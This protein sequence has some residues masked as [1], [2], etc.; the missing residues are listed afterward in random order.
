MDTSLNQQTYE[1][2]K[3]DILTFALKPGEPVSAQ[4][5]AERYDVSRTPAREALVRLQDEGMVDI[6]PQSRS[7]IS[8][9]KRDRIHQEWY[10]R[11]CL[12]LGMVDSFFDKVRKEDI[13][14]MKKAVVQLSKLGDTPRTHETSF[15]YI[16]CDDHFHSIMYY[17]TGESLAASIIENTLLN[18]R[19]VRLLVD[20]DNINKDRTVDDHERLIKLLEKKDREGYRLLL[21]EHLSHIIED[22]K[23]LYKQFPEMFEE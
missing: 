15:D 7:V 12:E 5:I 9:I 4:R 10:V 2:L 17:V 13:S 23:R 1:K 18:Y 16:N 11:K 14:E 22:M 21:T 20:L 19:R 3:K 8:K 6:Y